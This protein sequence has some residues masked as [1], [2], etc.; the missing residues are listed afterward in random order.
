MAEG[1][2]W[3]VSNYAKNKDLSQKWLD[4]VTNQEN[5]EKFFEMVNEIPANQQA[6]ET[7]KAKN[8]ELTTAVIEQYETAQAMPNIPEM[9]E[10]WTGAEK[11]DVRC[12]IRFKKHQKNPQMKQCENNQ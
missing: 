9:G 8:D 2:G 12:S 11:L 10:V 4:Y 6:R 1:K 3:V 5:Q 7:A